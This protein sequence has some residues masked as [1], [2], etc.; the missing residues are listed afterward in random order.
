MLTS[1]CYSHL[2][3]KV[4]L[5][6][7]K[8]TQPNNENSMQYKLKALISYWRVGRTHFIVIIS[9]VVW[10]DI[11]EEVGELNRC[12][13]IKFKFVINISNNIMSEFEMLINTQHA[14]IK[15]A[16]NPFVVWHFDPL[17][18]SHG[19]TR[20]IKRIFRS[21]CRF[22]QL[23]KLWIS[24]TKRK[25]SQMVSFFL[26]NLYFNKISKEKPWQDLQPTVIIYCIASAIIT[27]KL[28]DTPH[29]VLY[30]R[31]FLLTL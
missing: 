21:F 29:H 30:H 26:L 1:K 9:S 12:K 2:F 16:Y 11:I 8:R 28:S 18:G 5:T 13:A 15:V 19:K 22:C 20:S 14:F 27:L 3:R 17:S 23:L 7:L 4:K 10:Y 31:S 24:L 25:F 6:T